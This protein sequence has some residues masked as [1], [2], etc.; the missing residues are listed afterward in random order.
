MQECM[1]PCC[2][3]TTCTLKADA[4]CAHGQCCQDCQVRSAPMNRIFY[5][6][7]L[8]NLEEL[9]LDHYAFDLY[10]SLS[11][12]GCSWSQRV[13]SAV[14]PVTPATCQSF[15]RAT[16]LTA[17]PTSTYTMA[18][19]ATTWTATAITAY[20]RLMSSSAS[21]CGAKVCEGSPHR[22]I[23]PGKGSLWNR[24]T[25][26][27]RSKASTGHLL[28]KGQFSRRPLWQLWQGLERL[29]R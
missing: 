18:M 21:H 1:N 19:P 4:V 28:W 15:A 9:F 27:C 11:A 2:N 20:A 3:A 5:W 22:P 7:F 29:L 23:L 14:S 25:V 16:T 12:F 13:L 10:V 26:S 8:N 24:P 6:N 17:P